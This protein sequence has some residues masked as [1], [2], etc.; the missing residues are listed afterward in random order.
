MTMI[1]QNEEQ[2]NICPLIIISACKSH[3][4][5]VHPLLTGAGGGVQCT[6]IRAGEMLVNSP[7][8]PRSVRTEIV[9]HIRVYCYIVSTRGYLTWWSVYISSKQ[10]VSSEAK[11]LFPVN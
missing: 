10:S 2:Y 8:L 7:T 1:K 5:G 6:A 11:Y 3:C 9:P 4:L